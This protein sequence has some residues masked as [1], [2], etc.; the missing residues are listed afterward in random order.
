L[1]RLNPSL[2]SHEFEAEPENMSIVRGLRNSDPVVYEGLINQ[3]QHRLMHY[4]L[5]LTGK[6]EIAEDLF[7]E[8]WLR[9]L[10]RGA[11]YSG[12]AGFDSWLFTIARHLVIDLARKRSLYSL[13][14]MMDTHY[15]HRL[16]ERLASVPS[17]L[18]QLEAHEGNAELNS[19]LRAIGLTYREVLLLRF[20]KDFSLQEIAD[21]LRLPPS[22][23][24]ARLYR[25]LAIVKTKMERVRITRTVV[26][27][28]CVTVKI[29]ADLSQ[30]RLWRIY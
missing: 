22:T 7:Q 11:Q 14:E 5:A 2:A 9:V 23:V 10:I 28:S 19:V 29:A 15:E 1:H 6:H 24:K 3:Y 21:Q 20:Y 16:F 27:Q 18:S 4:L 26:S 13:E 12:S 25:G 30:S 8:T 17:P